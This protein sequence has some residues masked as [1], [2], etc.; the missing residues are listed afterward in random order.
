LTQNNRSFLE[1]IFSAVSIFAQNKTYLE[2]V[3]ETKKSFA[4]FAYEK[5]NKNRKGN[6]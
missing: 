2:K 3:V 6:E 4:R 1:I 5:R